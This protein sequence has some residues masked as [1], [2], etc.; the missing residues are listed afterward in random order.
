MVLAGGCSRPEQ[1]RP[2]TA[3]VTVEGGGAL[4]AA[5]AGRWISRQDGWEL[6]I[7]PDSRIAS[8]VISLG[9][10]RV[11]PG[12]TT[13]AP[14]RGETQAVFTPGPWMAYYVPGTRELTV[15]IVMDHVRIEMAGS[16]L[17]GSSTD[18]FTGP[19]APTNDTWQTQWTTFTRYTARTP[20]NVSHNLS[21]DPL[22]GEI[23][24]LV[25]DRVVTSLP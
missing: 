21:S 7:E 17:E 4:P 18:V 12:R 3:H 23:R 2:D 15:K 20:D 1:A 9:R 25:F 11:V 10:V 13:T 19:V 5:L 24:P 6:D 16:I 22:N 14:T 8:A